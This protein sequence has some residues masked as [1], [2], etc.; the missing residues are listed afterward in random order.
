LT[1]PFHSQG[2]VTAGTCESWFVSSHHPHGHTF[3]VH[4]HPFQVLAVDGVD[5]PTPY[6]RDT[7]PIMSNATVQVCFDKFDSGALLVHCHMPIH[8][9][10][11]MGGFYAIELPVLDQPTLAPTSA[12]VDPP[13]PD[14]LS[15]P[16]DTNTP[17][18]VSG[19]MIFWVVPIGTA[20]SFMLLV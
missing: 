12:P 8:Q 15:T 4:G 20:L 17:S 7:M 1:T 6:F 13:E 5:A 9:D 3:H 2:T 19:T 11:G 10:V 18:S 16:A 14:A